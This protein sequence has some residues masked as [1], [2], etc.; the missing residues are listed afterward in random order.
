MAMVVAGGAGEAVGPAGARGGTS[1]VVVVR[2][3]EEEGGEVLGRAAERSVGW[4][5]EG[6]SAERAVAGSSGRAG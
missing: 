5:R 3:V 6:A 4:R 2:V 1:V